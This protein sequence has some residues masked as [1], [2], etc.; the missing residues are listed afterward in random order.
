[1][2][3]H[4]VRAVKSRSVNQRW[5]LWSEYVSVQILAF[6]AIDAYAYLF[7][8]SSLYMYLVLP[9]SAWKCWIIHFDRQHEKIG[10]TLESL[11]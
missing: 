1:M 10:K 2:V 7:S 9:K 11:R 8:A 4:V 3:Y 6:T 5:R